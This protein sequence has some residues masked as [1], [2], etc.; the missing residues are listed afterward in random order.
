[1]RGWTN[2]RMPFIKLYDEKES[3]DGDWT[4][5]IGGGE[6]VTPTIPFYTVGS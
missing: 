5:V 3:F 2:K 6:K 4:A 1:M